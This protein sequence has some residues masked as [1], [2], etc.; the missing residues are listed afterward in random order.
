MSGNNV[1]D[2]GVERSKTKGIIFGR[3]T[4]SGSSITGKSEGSSSTIFEQ[5]KLEKG[6]KP[7]DLDAIKCSENIKRV[8]DLERDTSK[9]KRDA[10]SYRKWIMSQSI[11]DKVLGK[12][13][14]PSYGWVSKENE[15]KVGQSLLPCYK[16][17]RSDFDSK[18]YSSFNAKREHNL[19]G[20]FAPKAVHGEASTAR[21]PQ[22]NDTAGNDTKDQTLVSK[23]NDGKEPVSQLPMRSTEEYADDVQGEKPHLEI[24]TDGQ[25]NACSICSLGG[26]LLTCSGKGCKR[27][28]H[29]SCLNPPLINDPPRIW[30][31]ILC[32]KKKIELGV[33]AVS[34]EIESIWDARKVVSD[35]KVMQMEKQYLVK[36]QGL[37]HVHNCWIPETKLLLEAPKLVAKFNRKNQDIRWR[38][39]WTVPH[40]LLLKRQLSFSKNCDEYFDEHVMSK[41]DCSHE[42]LVKWSGLGYEHATWEL[43]NASFLRSP[44]AMKLIIDYE[45]RHRKGSSTLSEADKNGAKCLSEL[46]ELTLG[47]SSGEYNRHLRY[48]N[49]LRACWQK[50]QNAVILDDQADQERVLKVILF[51][52]SLQFI[53]WKPFLVI[54]TSSALSLWESEF[55]SVAP[56][57]N[58]IL[59]RGNK[60]VR[61]SIRT[62]EFYNESGCI[63]FQVL[64]ASVVVVVEDLEILE[65]I[66]WGAVIIDECQASQMSR[67]FEQIKMLPTDMR[68][69]LVSGQVKECASDYH[70][71][72]SLLNAAHGLSNDLTKIDSDN[73]IAKLKD[74]FAHYIAFQCNS[75]SSRFVE[76]WVPVKLSNLQLE[77]YCSTLL[78]NSMLLNS[79]LKKDPAHALCDVIISARKCCDHPYLLDQSLQSIITKGLSMEEKLDVEVKASGKL[80]LLDKILLES[81]RRGLRVLILFQVFMFCIHY[82]T[83]S[84][85]YPT[86]LFGEDSYVCIY[87]EFPR[88]RKQASVN[89]F[90]DKK[91]GRFVFL[92]EDRACLP[93]IKLTAVDIIILFDS[94][95]NPQSDLKALQRITICSQSEKL[96]VFRLYSS[97]TVEE[98][99]LILAKEG[100]AMDS[101]MCTLNWN[102]CYTL[103]SWGASYLFNKLD[104]FHGCCDSASVSNVYHEQ[105]FLN[106]ILSELLNLLPCSSESGHSTKNSIITEVPQDGVYVRN[107]FLY[108]EREIEFTCNESPAVFWKNLLKGRHP[109]WKFLS[110]SSSRIREKVQYI[111]YPS[112]E[113]EFKYDTFREK[114]VKVVS[115]TDCQAHLKW[116]TKGKRHL[117]ASRKKRKL[118]VPSKNSTG[119]KRFSCSPDD[120][121]DISQITT[122]VEPGISELCR[123]LQLPENVRGAALEFLG[124]ITKY[125]YVSWEAVATSQAFQISVC[126]M[127]AALLDYKIDWSESLTLAKLQLNFVCNE[128]EAH[129]IYMKLQ[130]VKKEF[131]Q[132]SNSINGLNKSDYASSK[133]SMTSDLQESD[134]GEIPV[135][136]RGENVADQLAPATCDEQL[137]EISCYCDA[138][139]DHAPLLDSPPHLCPVRHMQTFQSPVKVKP[140]EK[141][142]C[143]EV[144]RDDGSGKIT[145][146]LQSNKKR[147][148]T[149]VL[150]KS[151]HSM[152]SLSGGLAASGVAEGSQSVV[153]AEVGI[154]EGN[155]VS[156][157]ELPIFPVPSSPKSTLST[158]PASIG[159][160]HLSDGRHAS[161]Q[162]A[163]ISGITPL[164][165]QA[166]LC[167]PA[168]THPNANLLVQSFTSVSVGEAETE[169]QNLWMQQLPISKISTSMVSNLS[170]TP[171]SMGKQQHCSDGRDASCQEAQILGIP[172]LEDPMELSGLSIAHTSTNLPVQ[173]FVE[174]PVQN[175]GMQQL[176]VSGVS[177]SMASNLSSTPGSGGIQ[178]H[179]SD[180]RDA[181]CQETQI[182]KIPTLQDPVE[183]SSPTIAHTSMNLPVQA[184]IDVETQVQNL[185]MQQLPISKVSTSTASILSSI[186]ASVG[187]QH[188]S[189][190]RDASCLEAQISRI[191]SLQGPVELS[192]PA[193]AHGSTNLPVQPF[194]EVETQVQNLR[195]LEL[196][197]S[198]VSSPMATN[199]SP[200]RASMGI[201]HLPNGRDACCQED[202]ISGIPS[203]QD[204]VVL[205]SSTVTHPR[206]NLVQQQFP[207]VSVGEKETQVQNIRVQQLPRSTVSSF[208]ASNLSAIQASMGVEHL[209]NERHASCQEAQVPRQ[210]SLQELVGFCSLPVIQS[211]RNLPMQ[212]FGGMSA[213][214]NDTQVQNPTSR[215]TIFQSLHSHPFH[216]NLTRT[217]PQ[218][219]CSDPFQ[220]EI[221]RLAKLKVEASKL[222]EH[223]IMQLKSECNKEIEETYKKYDILFQ[224]A[225][226]ALV[227]RKKVLNAYSNKVF[228]NKLLAE[229]LILKQDYNEAAASPDDNVQSFRNQLIQQATQ[230][231]LRIG[232]P[233]TVDL[234]AAPPVQV[235]N[236]S[237]IC[238][239]VPHPASMTGNTVR[240]PAPHLR[241]FNPPSMSTPPVP[242]PSLVSN[243]QVHSNLETVIGHCMENPGF[244]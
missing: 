129:Y 114:R 38:T 165:D 85:E 139:Q 130:S 222:H 34:G 44:E 152:I 163:Q 199:L 227:E 184:F 104:D 206:T 67:H 90:N 51:V 167:S 65:R 157:K 147:S 24:Q 72:L 23:E 6:G 82:A 111:E 123:V 136:S 237:S 225:E 52:L 88:A 168:V 221:E 134:R 120:T 37:A 109:T 183:L 145:N 146:T 190:A 138:L 58:I 41:S 219:G 29:L 185:R 20:I 47:G 74:I 1:K 161:I 50:N 55:L 27:S 53:A 131:T 68:L 186:S 36:Y 61:S 119:A 63:M 154:I 121:N 224:D 172:S 17:Q 48:V 103:L 194:G 54:S 201:Q 3:L 2:D 127:A 198:E 141:T 216:A 56:S 110:N 170:S 118:T 217:L 189:D 64:L 76:Y 21:S 113:S 126:W 19:H 69:L 215:A 26:K 16:R 77:Q 43:E 4:S 128:E 150:E 87:G 179:C 112:R 107:I 143:S 207:S 94:N 182:S 92:I 117:N 78:S 238:T 230:M 100:M 144:V 9:R 30:H 236:H 214:E 13:D 218:Y 28:Y 231:P 70:S 229:T 12:I 99:V 200:R 180:G 40:R 181:F 242:A 166:E 79:H 156:S 160:Q 132:C 8:V 122:S 223:M 151:T 233:L 213:G 39:E 133:T 226:I 11:K 153:Q 169:V 239:A 232:Q 5:V 176:P 158:I 116:K 45:T 81:K 93:S 212:P 202:Q 57:S 148:D 59:Y 33:L 15:E 10:R 195:M 105:S 46:S 14:Q 240:A 89:M 108:G 49:K 164:Q 137:N 75:D 188:L 205:S 35:S 196:S 66:G 178:Q 101:N 177:T 84:Q 197:V 228:L 208:M 60:D 31:C 244:Q 115:H 106:D 203:L 204:L 71:L 175:L 62:L 7:I 192:S 73:D 124:Y 98:K 159:T 220:I 173:P 243:W 97:C 25:H 95:W 210:S 96:K 149:L 241:A 187:I 18:Q 86:C 42:W 234:G 235:F 211:I 193:I 162:E 135:D 125:Y 91:G 102:S 83:V 209:S 142:L 171:A 140:S 191:P 22:E 32:V 80:Q 155:S 174:T